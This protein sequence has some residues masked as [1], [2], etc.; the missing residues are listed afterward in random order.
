MG[1]A[2]AAATLACGTPYEPGDTTASTTSTSDTATADAS[3]T[4]TAGETADTGIQTVTSATTS[5]TTSATTTAVTT[6]ADACTTAGDAIAAMISAGQPCDVLVHLDDAAAPLGLAIVC[7]A[8]GT[9]WSAGKEIGDAT[10]CCGGGATVYPAEE[11]APLYVLHKEDPQGPDGV[12]L[13]SNHTGR[14]LLDATTGEGGPGS[15]AVPEA[16][17][18]PAGLAPAMGCGDRGFSLE[19]AQSLDLG[20]AGATLGEADLAALAAAIGDTALVPALAGVS[21]QVR[22]L[23]VRFA[24]EDGGPAHD[25]VLLEVAGS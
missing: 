19:S 13:L 24:L 20:Q 15:F 4:S 25:F 12:A 23:V 2:L 3:T 8:S 17:S 18:D 14:V 10:E 21:T 7:G 9:M 11:S 5:T 22:A 16:W 1:P 6:G